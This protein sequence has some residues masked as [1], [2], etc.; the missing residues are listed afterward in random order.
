MVHSKFD[1]FKVQTLKGLLQ[2]LHALLILQ[3]AFMCLWA[4]L[5]CIITRLLPSF[6]LILNDSGSMMLSLPCLTAGTVFLK[7]NVWSI[8]LYSKYVSG[9]SDQYTVY[10]TAAGVCFTETDW[11]VQCFIEQIS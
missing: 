5:S 9:N 8:F 3:A 2:K 10:P 11:M 4:S 1:G 6:S 7:L